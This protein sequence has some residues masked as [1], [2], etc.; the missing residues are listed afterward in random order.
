MHISLS[1]PSD[2]SGMLYAS[3]TSL[4]VCDV[5]GW[6]DI[7]I[8][9]R[10]G[11][12][13]HVFNIAVLSRRYGQAA[14]KFRG[15]DTLLAHKVRSNGYGVVE[16][17][18][19]D[20]SFDRTVKIPDL[21]SGSYD[22]SSLL[23]ATMSMLPWS[24]LGD[25]HDIKMFTMSPVEPGASMGTSGSVSVGQLRAM[26]KLIRVSGKG[27]TPDEIADMAWRAATE[28]V[29]MEAGTQD[30]WS[31]AYSDGFSLMEID[32]PT[33]KRRGLV[34]DRE[35]ERTLESC[36]ITV[37]VGQHD[38]SSMHKKVKEGLADKGPDCEQL[39]AFDGLARRAFDCI[40]Q[41]GSVEELG[42]ICWLNTRAQEGLHPELVGPHHT[43]V[44]EWAQKSGGFIAPKI[45]GAGGVGGSV[46]LWFASPED[47]RRFFESNKK[48]MA[49]LGFKC[50]EHQIAHC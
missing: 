34:I 9:K 48:E 39:S 11:R 38:S 18:A 3:T 27:F 16:M 25:H 50:Y 10:V 22:N 35:Y 33:T 46:S 44:I 41:R 28:K 14:S 45:N 21:V 7:E 19:D 49:E 42:E 6:R 43:V 37:V 29:G 4:R 13:N 15:I 36:L 17:I 32:F 2:V 31:A 40:S 26:N 8:A 1:A 12:P 20:E 5:G 30:E 47:V 23:A 24:E